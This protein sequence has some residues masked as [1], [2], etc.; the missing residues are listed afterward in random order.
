MKKKLGVAIAASR[1]PVTLTTEALIRTPTCRST[2]RTKRPCSGSPEAAAAQR[3]PDD[4]PL[5]V[6]QI[7]AHQTDLHKDQS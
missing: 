4:R 2:G 5:F 7:A 6:C 3:C 1:Q